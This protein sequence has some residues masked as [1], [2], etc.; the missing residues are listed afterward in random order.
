MPCKF[1]RVLSLCRVPG[2]L[3]RVHLAH[4]NVRFSCSA[5]T[6]R[7][8]GDSD[9]WE[10]GCIRKV[11]KTARVALLPP[12]GVERAPAVAKIAL[13]GGGMEL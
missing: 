8:F 5:G 13:E 2:P 12:S 9:A 7:T 3:C 1:C 11:E 4:G 6:E 10:D